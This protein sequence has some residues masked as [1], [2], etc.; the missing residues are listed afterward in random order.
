[1]K[2]LKSS[3]KPTVFGMWILLVFF[4]HSSVNA[5]SKKVLLVP[6]RSQNEAR[7]ALNESEDLDVLLAKDLAQNDCRA[8]LSRFN[9]KNLT[10]LKPIELAIFANCEPPGKDPEKIFKFAEEQ[11]KDDEAIPLLHAR[12][13]TRKF[14]LNADEIWKRLADE[15]K[16]PTVK[17]IA[18]DYIENQTDS[19]QAIERDESPG[20]VQFGVYDSSNPRLVANSDESSNKTSSSMLSLS[21]GRTFQMKKS[22]GFVEESGVISSNFFP[23][24][25]DIDTGSADGAVEFGVQTGP[26]RY[27]LVS[28][29]GDIT[30]FGGSFF[31]GFAGG[32]LG[33]LK[34]MEHSDYKFM[35]GVYQDRFILNEYQ[36]QGGNHLKLEQKLNGRLPYDVQLI[37]V[38]NLEHA[39]LGQDVSESQLIQYSNS[40]YSLSFAVSK[41]LRGFQ[42]GA[43]VNVTARED[44]QD[45]RFQDSNGNWTSKRR[46]DYSFREEFSIGHQLFE[47]ALVT[48]FARAFETKS[49]FDEASV[50]RNA[51]DYVIGLNIRHWIW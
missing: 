14:M 35:F 30:Y 48:I 5:D 27:F 45:S 49:N 50:D 6:S 43:G 11:D 1:M 7:G 24:A 20:F 16:N 23:S 51:R 47:K 22:F 2:A 46:V 38:L 12:Y 37:A 21:I 42:I 36:A 4:F 26:S 10:K 39:N 9:A 3:L 32:G 25:H 19:L 8:S 41:I 34:R 40:L 18:S 28:T 17:A 29:Y 15:A 31:Y 33:V 13:R 44:D